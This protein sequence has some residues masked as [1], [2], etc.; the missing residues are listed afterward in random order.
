MSWPRVSVDPVHQAPPKIG[1]EESGRRELAQWITDP[2]NPLTARVMVN[3][4]WEHLFGQGIV[5]SVDNFGIDRREAVA[6]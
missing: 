4:I 2:S 3:R 1:A 5:K 6:P